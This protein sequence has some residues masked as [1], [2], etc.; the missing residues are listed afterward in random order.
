M[1]KHLPVPVVHTTDL[2]ETFMMAMQVWHEV[3][4]VARYWGE[5]P[6]LHPAYKSLCR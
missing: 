5:L 6:D 2:D 1:D 4:D 3:R